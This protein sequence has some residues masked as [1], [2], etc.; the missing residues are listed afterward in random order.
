MNQTIAY[1]DNNA[2]EFCAST[3]DADMSC[4]REKFVQYLSGGDGADAIGENTCTFTTIPND[5]TIVKDEIKHI[6]DAGCGS[7]RDSKVFMELGYQVT[8][9]DASIKMCAKA[10]K[11]IGQPVLHMTFDEIEFENEFDGIWACASLLHIAKNEM[12]DILKRFRLA[13]KEDGIIYASFK[14]G[15]DERVVNGRFFNDYDEAVAEL[16]ESNGFEILE[17][18]VTQDVREDKGRESWVNVVGRK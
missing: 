18:F 13:L 14:Y 15:N 2:E 4:C 1:Y 9:I 16:F 11:W 3:Q 10:E 5:N 17:V 7:G 6:L 12:P 8:A